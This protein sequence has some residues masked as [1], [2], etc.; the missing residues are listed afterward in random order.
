MTGRGR[1]SHW[2]RLRSVA[3]NAAFVPGLRPGQLVPALVVAALV[4][5]ALVVP[6][7]VVADRQPDVGWHHI[8][9]RLST[10]ST[11]TSSVAAQAA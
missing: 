1:R 2:P 9:T 6:A 7:L 8:H 5:A 3:T 11:G 4:V 10:T